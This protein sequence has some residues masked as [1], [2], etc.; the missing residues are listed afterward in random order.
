MNFE[1]RRLAN[2]KGPDENRVIQLAN[3]VESFTCLLLDPL[4]SDQRRREE[5]GDDLDEILEDA[6]HLQQKRYCNEKNRAAHFAN[7]CILNLLFF[8]VPAS[9]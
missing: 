3:S 4:K 6:I 9:E 7:L 5:F 2:S 1:L 8:I